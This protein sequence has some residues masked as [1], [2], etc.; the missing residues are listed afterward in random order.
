L[1]E[2]VII[3]DETNLIENLTPGNELAIEGPF[4]NDHSINEVVHHEEM[5]EQ[6]F[7]EDYP[8]LFD[9]EVLMIKD[10]VGS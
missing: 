4:S 7:D 1:Q 2:E 9:H 3:E 10:L 5:R 8:P 6:S